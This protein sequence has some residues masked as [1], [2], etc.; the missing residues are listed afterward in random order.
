MKKS[1]LSGIAIGG[2][3]LTTAACGGNSSSTSSKSASGLTNVRIAGDWVEPDI[4]WLPYTVGIEQG[5]Y[6]KAGIAA[7][8]VRPPDNSSSVKFVATNQAEIA[9]ATV[10]DIIFAGQQKLPVESIGNLSQTN[11]W[12]LF[13]LGNKP[14]TAASLKGKKIGVFNDSFTKALLPLVLAS[15]GLTM[16]DVQQVTAQS[17]NTELLMNGKIDVASNT[18]NFGG[19]QIAEKAGKAPQTLLAK[20]AGAPDMPIWVYAANTSWLKSN[21]DTA[22]KFM[23]ATRQATQWAMKNPAKAVASYEKYSKIPAS[24]TK[25]DTAEWKATVPLLDAGS[26]LFTSTDQQWS[27]IASALVKTKQIPQALPA[28]NYYTNAYLTP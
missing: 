7:S 1:L 9:E 6:K 23:E 25:L 26:G 4:T 22:K 18:T 10:S 21:P 16:N 24:S 20:D 15:A 27:G 28:G 8:I 17:G 14:L 12:G 5:F 3:V 11:N 2:L 13:S 19:A